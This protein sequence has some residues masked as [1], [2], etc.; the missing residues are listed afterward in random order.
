MIE[1]RLR[2]KP[3]VALIS[4]GLLWVG[5][6]WVGLLWA[7]LWLAPGSIEAAEPKLFRFQFSEVHMATDFRIILYAPN[8]NTA[9][10]AVQAAFTRVG[11]IDQ[12]L[13]D[14]RPESELN[15]WCRTAGMGTAVPLSDDLFH[16]VDASQRLAR[17]TN[18]AF[19]VTLGPYTRLWRRA[20]RRKQLPTADQLATARRAVGYRNVRLNSETRTGQLLRKDMR[21]DLGGIA[22]GYAA[23][24]ALLVLTQHGLPHALVDG[25]GDISAGA[26]PPGTSGW[27]IGLTNLSEV[28]AVE[29][30]LLI[31]HAAVAT[32]GDGW[33]HVTIDGQRYSHIINPQT[34]LGLTAARH[35]TVVAPDGITADSLASALSVLGPQRGLKLLEQRKNVE[36]RIL[37][38]TPAGVVSHASD[39]FAELPNVKSLAD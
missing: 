33:Q 35:V 8:R 16:V 15:R 1:C 12:R 34:G 39:G 20:R 30:T 18:G 3:F 27:R 22:K 4:S 26:P 21:I 10:K 14:Y 11:Q 37:E 17:Q 25:S 7:G 32:S 9:N 19:D 2:D 29:R 13:S 6:L 38:K 24:Q 36:A 5:L 23:D 28:S 31:A